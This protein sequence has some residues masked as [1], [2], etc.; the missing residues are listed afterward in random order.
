MPSSLT[1]DPQFDGADTAAALVFICAG[2]PSGDLLA[3]ALIRELRLVRPQTR[4]VGVTGPAMRAQGCQTLADIEEL[5]VMGLFEVLPHLPR[6]WRLKRRL[7][8][9]ALALGADIF[10]GVD[11]PGFNLRLAGALKRQGLPTVH[12]VSPQVWAWRS[13]RVKTMARDLDRVL[14]LLPF[15]SAFYA[16]RGLS[17]DYVG[18]PMADQIPMEPDRLQ[19]RE[20]LGLPLTGRQVALLPGSRRSEIERLG[21]DFIGAAAWLHERR[22]DL[23][24]ILPAAN[25]AAEQRLLSWTQGRDLPIKVLRGQARAA[26]IASDVALVAS[27]TATLETLLCKRPMVVAYRLGAATAWLLRRFNLVK[28]RFFSQPNLL[29]NKALVPEVFQEEVTPQRLGAEILSWLDHPE[30]VTELLNCFKT[31]HL[32]LRQDSAAKAAAVVGQVLDR[33]RGLR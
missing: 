3:A 8:N 24:F 2:E 31:I 20:Q 33:A 7:V 28:T 10:V 18:H 6:L 16:Q 30:R 29:A 25:L 22:P 19:A 15:E 26:M 13:G 9:E 5:S 21:P 4:F 1:V 27:G 14:C 23:V 17:A 11:F 32:T 12:Y